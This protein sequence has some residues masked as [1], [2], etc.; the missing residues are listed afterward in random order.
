MLKNLSDTPLGVLIPEL[1]RARNAP[2]VIGTLRRDAT[3]QGNRAE[4]NKTISAVKDAQLKFASVMPSCQ[5]GSVSFDKYFEWIDGFTATN[6][7]QRA[8]AYQANALD[9]ISNQL[10]TIQ[11]LR[12]AQSLYLETVQAYNDTVDAMSQASVAGVVFT[13]KQ[14]EEAQLIKS[15]EQSWERPADFMVGGGRWFQPSPSELATLAISDLPRG[16]GILPLHTHGM[17]ALL[18][19]ARVVDNPNLH[20][21]ALRHGG[22]GV[23]G[24]LSAHLPVAPPGVDGEVKQTLM[25]GIRFRGIGACTSRDGLDAFALPVSQQ[26]HG[27]NG[28]GGSAALI[29]QDVAKGTEIFL[30]LLDSTGIHECAHRMTR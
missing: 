20:G 17:L 7:N 21:F 30:K 25:H 23:L 28:E 10:E 22:N 9:K 12:K 26:P 1:I 4:L 24:R 2:A 6:L 8:L 5:L 29:S 13:L 15:P 18:E 11:D 3:F 16:A 14:A 27:V 19:E